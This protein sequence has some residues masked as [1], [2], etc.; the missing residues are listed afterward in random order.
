M[1]PLKNLFSKTKKNQC[2]LDPFTPQV[3]PMDKKRKKE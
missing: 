1:N 3:I 2:T